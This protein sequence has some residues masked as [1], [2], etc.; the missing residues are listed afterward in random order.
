MK[1]L[2]ITGNAQTRNYN[3]VVVGENKMK[4]QENTHDTVMQII[5]LKMQWD[6]IDEQTSEDLFFDYSFP[7]KF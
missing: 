3:V 2:K 7:I 6:I 4:E 5:R 1:C